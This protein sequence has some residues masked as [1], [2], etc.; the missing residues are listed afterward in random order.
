MLS[1]ILITTAIMLQFINKFIILISR[2]AQLGSRLLCF[3]FYA[4]MQCSYF[5]PIMLNIMLMRKLVPHFIPCHGLIT[6]I[7]TMKIFIKT[8]LNQFEQQ[9]ATMG[10]STPGSSVAFHVLHQ[11]LGSVRTS[12]GW[13]DLVVVH[14]T[15]Q[16]QHSFIAS[17]LLWT[18]TREVV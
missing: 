5:S 3:N 17:L 11:P 14:V 16:E 10:L 2:L 4:R 6:I 15:K 7:Y 9:T 1:I 18:S 13:F 8:V 12:I